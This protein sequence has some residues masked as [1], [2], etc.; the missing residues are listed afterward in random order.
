MNVDTSPV[1]PAG[2]SERSMLRSVAVPT[3]HGGWGPP[4]QPVVLG[5]APAPRGA[6][7][8]LWAAPGAAV[9]A[10]AADVEARVA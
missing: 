4:A 9:V 1:A 10:R 2:K 6:R 5:L 3:E 7:A 8:C